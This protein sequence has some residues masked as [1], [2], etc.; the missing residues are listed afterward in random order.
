MKV[1]KVS[2]GDSY[3]NQ[4]SEQLFTTYSSASNG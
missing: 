1:A 2:Y 3:Q 4:S